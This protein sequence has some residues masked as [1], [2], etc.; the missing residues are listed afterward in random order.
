MKNAVENKS[1][2]GG[3]VFTRV[4]F[5]MA[6][7]PYTYLLEPIAVFP[8]LYLDEAKKLWVSYMHDGQHGACLKHFALND[9]LVPSSKHLKAVAALKDELEHLK[10]PYVLTVLDAAEWKKE[11]AVLAKQLMKNAKHYETAEEETDAGRCSEVEE[12]KDVQADFFDR[13]FDDDFAETKKTI[14]SIFDEELGD[15]A[16]DIDKDY[17]DIPDD[18]VYPP[19]V[20]GNEPNL[21]AD[22]KVCAA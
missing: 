6:Q 1:A 2:N 17:S 21:M 11:N 5:L 12:K 3:K 13:L 20:V 4:V 14:A 19:M 18:L 9:C 15:I 7:D 10:E 16:A 8:D 22:L